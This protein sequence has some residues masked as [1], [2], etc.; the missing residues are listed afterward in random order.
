M[1][2]PSVSQI[3]DCMRDPGFDTIP[4]HVLEKARNRG[5]KG[6]DVIRDMLIMDIDPP[7]EYD[8]KDFKKWYND[9]GFKCKEMEVRAFEKDYHGKPDWVG[10]LGTSGVILDWKFK[11]KVSIR[12]YVQVAGGYS[13]L[14]GVQRAMI[15]QFKEKSFES[16]DFKKTDVLKYQRLFLNIKELFYAFGLEKHIK[17]DRSK[18]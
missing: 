5:I 8:L 9:K 13:L 17:E 2:I 3:L 16:F 14:K 10:T 12:D 1:I 6:H 4:T 15:I 11:Q 7:E 18:V